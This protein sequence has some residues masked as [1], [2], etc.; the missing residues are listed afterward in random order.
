MLRRIGWTLLMLAMPFFAIA[1]MMALTHGHEHLADK[2]RY[3][4]LLCLCS[5]T[6]LIGASHTISK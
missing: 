6:V 1:V 5:A 2:W 4:G 3:A